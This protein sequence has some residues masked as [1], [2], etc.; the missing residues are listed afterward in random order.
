MVREIFAQ[1]RLVIPA[2]LPDIALAL[3]LAT[4]AVSLAVIVS[5][6]RGLRGASVPE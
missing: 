6:I 1:D 3:A 5:A 4:A 2:G